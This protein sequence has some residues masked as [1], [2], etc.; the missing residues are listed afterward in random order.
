[1]VLGTV[2]N[3]VAFISAVAFLNA[4]LAWFGGL[5]GYPEVTFEVAIKKCYYFS[6]FRKN[7]Y[8]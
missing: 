2:A 6:Q 3:T 4:I 7:A 5:V 8:A 1:M